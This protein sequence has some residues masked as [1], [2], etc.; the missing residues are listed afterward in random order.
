MMTKG[1]AWLIKMAYRVK[2]K[3][4]RDVY[5]LIDLAESDEVVAKLRNIAELLEDRYRNG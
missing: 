2:M 5:Y 3:D 1:D 4:Y